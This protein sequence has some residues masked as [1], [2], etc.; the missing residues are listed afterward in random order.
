MRGPPDIG[1]R[2]K[3]VVGSHFKELGCD[4]CWVHSLHPA[5]DGIGLD[6]GP[7]ASDF[8]PGGDGGEKLGLDFEYLLADGGLG[9]L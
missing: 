9:W 7:D 8:A 1:V 2:Q 3:L 5:D 4:L 6:A